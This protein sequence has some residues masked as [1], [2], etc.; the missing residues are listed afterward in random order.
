MPFP[1]E[2]RIS[3]RYLRAKRHEAFISLS[4]WISIGGV[5]LGVMALIVVLGVM[6]GFESD[7][8]GK[9]L[10]ANPHIIVL[11]HD[12]RPVEEKERLLEQL[13]QVPGVVE[14]EPFVVS[15]VLLTSE[16]SVTGVILRGI[17]P[18]RFGRLT[19]FERMMREG[20][21]QELNAPAPEAGRG[22]D[23]GA[24]QSASAEGVPPPSGRGAAPTPEAIIL[25]KELAR[26][27]AVGLGQKVNVVS[28][29]G[30][31]TPMGSVPKL[32]AFRV[33]GIFQTGLFEYDNSLAFINLRNA[34]RFFDLDDLVSGVE[35]RVADVYHADRVARRINARLAPPYLARD[36]M[37]MNRN[38]FAA[39]QLERTVMFIIL[40]M[41][42]LVAAF[43]IISTLTMVV[44]EKR[45]EIAI[46]KSMGATHRSIMKIFIFQGL[47]IGVLGTL[48][49]VLGGSLIGW[50][51]Q[52]YHYIRLP[53]EVYLLDT[54]PFDLQPLMLI[55][56][57]VAALGLTF[58][59][60]LYP[61][62]SA[63]RV[64]PVEVLRYE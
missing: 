15:Q 57:S 16:R 61:A 24:S 51:L 62:W 56:V 3:W 4:T 20:S 40:V 43:N 11:R 58:I 46:L 17:D 21:L 6:G 49:G 29:L 59:A 31:A 18:Q 5:T 7:L 63:A 53:A 47:L 48:L 34:Q 2:V 54:L 55:T 39:L 12:Q 35:V 28:P 32:R 52:T 50:S 26:T 44:M 25:G 14:A 9:I 1:Y 30:E 8:R 64:Q 38:L 33:A 27:L 36:W 22:T 23:A 45:K 13:R 41:I 37:Q 19:S 42:V 60:T 10:G